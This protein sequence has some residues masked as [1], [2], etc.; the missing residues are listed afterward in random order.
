[1]DEKRPQ[2]EWL[3]FPW[4]QRDDGTFNSL[5]VFRF[6]HPYMDGACAGVFMA[7]CI[8]DDW[9]DSAAHASPPYIYDPKSAPPN[10]EWRF[11]AKLWA[12]LHVP[13]ILAISLVDLLTMKEGKVGDKPFTTWRNK[14]RK[15]FSKIHSLDVRDVKMQND[16][17]VKKKNFK[18]MLLR[19]LAPVLERSWSQMC[20]NKFLPDRSV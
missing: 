19:V 13:L 3:V 7:E 14:G 17:N 15:V 2:W 20:G 5:H 8:F 1:M 18:T 16:V 9:G 12:L 6:D 10:Q 4:I 11:V